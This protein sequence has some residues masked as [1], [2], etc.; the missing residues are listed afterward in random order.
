MSNGRPAEAERKAA[1]FIESEKRRIREEQDRVSAQKAID[2]ATE[3]VNG[4]DAEVGV[5]RPLHFFALVVVWCVRRERFI[6]VGRMYG[7]DTERGDDHMCTCYVRI[8][9][10]LVDEMLH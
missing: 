3:L 10:Q 7:G 2:E 4:L 8:Y 5:V 6:L 1:L 9:A